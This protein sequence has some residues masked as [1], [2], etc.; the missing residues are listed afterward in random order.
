VPSTNQTLKQQTAATSSPRGCLF[1]GPTTITLQ[2]NQM[3]VHSPWTRDTPICLLDQWIPVPA[4]GTV[5]VDD[6]P[7]NNT[8]DVNSWTTSQATA[9]QNVCNNQNGYNISGGNPVGFPLSNEADW[10]YSCTAGD[11]FI[12]ELDGSAANGLTGR[13]TVAA[14]G[15][16][17]V[18]GNIHYASSNGLLGLIANQYVWYWHP[19]DRNN[20]NITLPARQF[21]T[22]SAKSQP[23][24]NPTVSAAMVSLQHSIGTMHYDEGASLGTL[25]VNGS[26]T[27]L[28]RGV[29]KQ[30]SSGYDK[31]Y[32]YD[33]RLRYDAPPHFLNPTSSSFVMKLSAEIPAQFRA[34]E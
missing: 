1:V 20:Q 6:R 15:S 17:Y 29:V 2:G 12:Q 30:G 4:N 19:T 3:F 8:T 24:S 23:L 27:Q 14:A 33:Q 25:T 11:V 18:T 16:I 28:Y 9:V 13:L 21:P 34:N 10:S 5:Y 22:Q 7:A 31:N 26:I 32:V